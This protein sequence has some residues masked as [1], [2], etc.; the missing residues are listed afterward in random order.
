MSIHT[1]SF[2]KYFYVAPFAEGGKSPGSHCY[3]DC[4]MPV[5]AKEN[6]SGVGSAAAGQSHATQMSLAKIMTSE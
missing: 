2:L 3:C 4:T 1:L 5:A 6:T